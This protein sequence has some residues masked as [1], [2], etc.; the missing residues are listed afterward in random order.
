[1]AQHLL[2]LPTSQSLRSSVIVI[3]LSLLCIASLNNIRMHLDNHNL[4]VIPNFTSVEPEEACRHL[5]QDGL[6]KGQGVQSPDPNAV[7]TKDEN[8]T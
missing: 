3:Q 1:V 6:S 5:V 8:L 7:V 2:L 4:T